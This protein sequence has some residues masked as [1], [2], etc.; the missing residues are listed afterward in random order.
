MISRYPFSASALSNSANLVLLP[1]WGDARAQRRHLADDPCDGPRRGRDARATQRLWSCG[2]RR[3]GFT[4]LGDDGR[5]C[6]P[7]PAR[8]GDRGRRSGRGVG[9]ELARVDRRRARR[10]DRGR[11]AG[12]GQHAVPRHRS[13]VRPHAQRRSG[14]VHRARV[15]RHRLPGAARER[16]GRAARARAHG[17]AVGR[18]RRRVGRLGRVPRV[19]T[20]RAPTPTST[21]ASRRSDPTIRATWSSRPGRRA[22]RRASS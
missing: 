6:G 22:T 20:R 16:R 7:G 3:V 14:A 9:T 15:P 11:G 8:L 1:V 12:A 19:W 10:D 18:R 5:R 4:A 2:T 21:R 17:P 13:R